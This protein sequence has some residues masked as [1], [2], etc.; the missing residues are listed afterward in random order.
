MKGLFVKC[1][2]ARTPQ[3]SQ[4]ETFSWMPLERLLCESHRCLHGLSADIEVYLRVT[5]PQ[6][7]RC[8]TI[9]R[10]LPYPVTKSSHLEHHFADKELRP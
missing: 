5:F 3:E 2:G 7:I 4:V 9:L 8:S 6:F 10:Y 1:Q